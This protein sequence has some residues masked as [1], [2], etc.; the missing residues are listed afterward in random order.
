M[1]VSNGTLGILYKKT[2]LGRRIGIGEKPDP[3]STRVSITAKR[4]E[5]R[6]IIVRILIPALY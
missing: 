3:A 4:R 5:W 2:N 1:N 6:Q